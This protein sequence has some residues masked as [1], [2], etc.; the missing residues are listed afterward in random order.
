[1]SEIINKISEEI[2]KKIDKDSSEKKVWIEE[3]INKKTETFWDKVNNFF[4]KIDIL[5]L[6]QEEKWEVAQKVKKDANP[7][8]LYRIEIFLSGII[9]SLG[10]L[11]NSV[12]VIIGA[13]L[14]APFLRPINGIAFGIARWERKFFINSVKVLFISSIVSIFMWFIVMN[15]T[16]LYKETPEIL[17]RTS[18]NII[19]LFI[20][21]FSAVV[22]LL[23]LW[24]KRLWESVAWVAM[25]ASLMPPLW[26]IW[27]ELALWNYALAWWALM[28]FITNIIAIILVWVGAFWLYWFTPNSWWKQKKSFIRIFSVV[29]L[30]LLISVPL[31]RNLLFLKDKALIEREI[32]KNLYI[33]LHK[34]ID[35]FKISKVKIKE[36]DSKNIKILTEIKITQWVKIYD[37]FKYYLEKE[38]SEKIWREVEVEIEPIIVAKIISLEEEEK[39]LEKIKNKNLEDLK[40]KQKEEE[41]KSNR[42]VQYINSIKTD[43]EREI[44]QKLEEE[45]SIKLKKEI[46]E[47]LKEDF[48]ILLEKKILEIQKNEE[49]LSEETGSWKV[50]K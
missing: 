49:N 39:M 21:I 29:F 17:A 11:Q 18:P 13:M 32:N 48:N 9:A 35:N 16:W 8:K 25:A 24:Y 3:K 46:E 12:A 19:D 40:N 42:Q 28:L 31:V 34:K 5:E 7:D 27:M 10:L 20:A 43:F 4:W 22:A 2:S 36:L 6:S 37:D 14:I 30:I 1:M 44:N 33:I 45:I 41:E 15:F 26:V 38:L 50:D 47:K 23:S